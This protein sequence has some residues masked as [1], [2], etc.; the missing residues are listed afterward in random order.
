MKIV[1]ISITDSGIVRGRTELIKEL[2]QRNHSVYVITPQGNDYKVL[3]EMGCEFFPISIQSHGTNP[4]KDFGVYRQYLHLLKSIAPDIVLTFTTK[5]NIYGGMACRRLQIPVLMN[6][7]GM[8]SA[9]GQKGVLQSLLV[10]MYRLACNGNNIKRIFFQNEDSKDFFTKH[11]IGNPNTYYRIPGSGVNLEKFIVQPFP[12]S[13]TIDFLFVARVLKE[14]GIEQYLDA[15]RYI[16]KKYPNTAFHVLGGCDNEYLTILKK[17]NAAGVIEY[18]GRVNN[19]VDFERISQCTIQPSYY[20]EGMSNVILEA[21][22]SGRP[23]ITTDHPGCREGVDDGVTG[24]IIPIK[25]SAALIN[26][27]ER[28]LQLSYKEK[29]KMGLAGRKKMEN[30]FNRHI[31]TDAYLEGIDIVFYH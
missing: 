1:I 5:P 8:G 7:T 2:L 31:V 17:E 25:N 27:V 11:G 4:L 28:F 30:E 29:V 19:M 9:L 16:H 15:A 22:A 23:V 26:A 10:R 6:I 14:K 24:Y 13:E 12:K 3:M 20:P 21:A 18:H